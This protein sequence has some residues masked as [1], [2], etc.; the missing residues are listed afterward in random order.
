MENIPNTVGTLSTPLAGYGGSSDRGIRQD[1]VLE[2]VRPTQMR[3]PSMHLRD[4]QCRR[5]TLV[6]PSFQVISRM[7]D[8]L[9]PAKARVS[10]LAVRTEDQGSE[11]ALPPPLG[12]TSL[13]N[14]CLT[15]RAVPPPVC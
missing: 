6:R 8:E 12:A 13:C 10:T 4:Y 11:R 3:R 9:D 7:A 15:R 14:P 2:E 5:I 1:T